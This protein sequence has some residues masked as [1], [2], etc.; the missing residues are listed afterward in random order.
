MVVISTA[1]IS[2]EV[3][4]VEKAHDQ[5]VKIATQA[6]GFVT[7]PSIAGEIEQATGRAKYLENQVALATIN[8]SLSEPVPAVQE[9]IRWD[10]VQTALKSGHSLGAIFRAIA[11]AAIWFVIWAPLWALFGGVFYG[12]KRFRT[13]RG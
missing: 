12:I 3:P 1:D 10:V 7:L 4:N 8:V 9:A 13:R 5:V 11:S 2:L 6:K